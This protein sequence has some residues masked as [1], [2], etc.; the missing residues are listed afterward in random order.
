[1]FFKQ[2]TAYEIPKRD[3]SSDVCSSDL[4]PN[5]TVTRKVELQ[6]PGFAVP[7][8]V[9]PQGY[10]SA[11]LELKVK[12]DDHPLFQQMVD[13]RVDPGRVQRRLVQGRGAGNG[14]RVQVQVAQRGDQALA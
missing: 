9:T 12:P 6:L 2:K 3:W 14:V 5:I 4:E 13:S 8:F 10:G 1:V 11:Y 7:C